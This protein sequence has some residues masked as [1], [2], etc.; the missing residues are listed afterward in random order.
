MQ[1][2]VDAHESGA[3]AFVQLGYLAV[4]QGQIV[5]HRVTFI[6]EKP[7]VEYLVQWFGPGERKAPQEWFEHRFVHTS[8]EAAFAP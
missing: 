5:G 2:T 6:D 4:K 7:A 8:A 3:I 1:I